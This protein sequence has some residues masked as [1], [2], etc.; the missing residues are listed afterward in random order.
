MRWRNH[1]DGANYKQAPVGI[2]NDV[3]DKL[4]EGTLTFEQAVTQ[5]RE[6]VT[7]S[8]IEAAAQAAGP[9]PH[10][11]DGCRDIYQGAQCP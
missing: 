2:A 9:A 5:A 1:H 10:R 3:N 4:A 7:R 8:R 6:H 11:A